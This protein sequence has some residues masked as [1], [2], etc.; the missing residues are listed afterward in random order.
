M[1]NEL[2]EQDETIEDKWHYW[3]WKCEVSDSRMR[4]KGKKITSGCGHVNLRKSQKTLVASGN[5][6]DK[7]RNAECR[8]GRRLNGGNTSV[9]TTKDEAVRFM[10]KVEQ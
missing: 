5:F 6:Q 2:I 8:R 9:F 7:C 3:V 10:R 1:K 4:P